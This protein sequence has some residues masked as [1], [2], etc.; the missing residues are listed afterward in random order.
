MI[1]I[2][3]CVSAF[4]ALGVIFVVEGM[5]KL[6]LSFRNCSILNILFTGSASTLSPVGDVQICPGQPKVFICT[7]AQNYSFSRLEWQINFK[8]ETS[9][10]SITEQF[11]SVDREGHAFEADRNGIN[12]H[13]NLTTK[14]GQSLVSVMKIMVLDDNG[15]SL[16]NNA[17]VSCGLV[18]EEGYPHAVIS[19]ITGMQCNELLATCFQVYLLDV[20]S[21]HDRK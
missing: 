14:E 12:I 5:T 3:F 21:T 8:D 9:V 15:S 10:P 17:T 18:G 20:R 1:T 4:G 2:K 7:V 11:T 19:A 6:S 13:F 16:I